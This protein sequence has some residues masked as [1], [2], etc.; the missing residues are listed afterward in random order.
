[1]RADIERQRQ[2][3]KRLE[4]NRMARTNMLRTRHD[5]EMEEQRQNRAKITEQHNSLRSVIE[6]NQMKPPNEYKG[7][8]LSTK[9][10]LEFFHRRY[11]NSKRG[12][13]RHL[14]K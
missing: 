6:G 9:S 10:L 12:K 5:M 1:M 14:A 4:E 2:E 11:I 8:F 13:F 3:V 7:Q